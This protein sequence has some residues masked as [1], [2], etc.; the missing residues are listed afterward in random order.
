MTEFTDFDR[1]RLDK[2]RCRHLLETLPFLRSAK[3]GVT[4]DRTFVVH[5]ATPKSVDRI[6]SSVTTLLEAIDLQGFEHCALYF[7]G[8]LL[9][10]TNDAPAKNTVESKHN[11]STEFEQMTLTTTVNPIATNGTKSEA[12]EP[13][14]A[15][16]IDKMRQA[17]APAVSEEIDGLTRELAIAETLRQLEAPEMPEKVHAVVKATLADVRSMLRADVLGETSTEA[18]APAESPL[19]TDDTEVKPEAQPIKLIR[20][21]A[22]KRGN[23]RA[24]T[25][26]AFL[27]AQ[28]YGD[29]K[30]S[31]MLEA[32]ATLPD[33]QADIGTPGE[34]AL[35]YLLRSIGAK[36]NSTNRKA[37]IAEAQKLQ[38]ALGKD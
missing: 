23:T 26:A 2:A 10:S 20:F 32:I 4:L 5:A 16:S 6:L 27:D 25:I 17:I 28:G 24:K 15:D 12:S 30:R 8:E 14:N 21:K 37:F 36:P 22:F 38:G 19:P 29:K 3:V 7:V 1:D 34:Q 33:A 9:W 13:I 31:E 35:S 11:H 18:I